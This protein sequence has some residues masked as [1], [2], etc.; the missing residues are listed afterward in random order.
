M[1]YSRL[2]VG[3][4]FLF[5]ERALKIDAPKIAQR[6]YYTY[7]STG[8]YPLQNGHN[9]KITAQQDLYYRFITPLLYSGLLQLTRLQGNR[10][11]NLGIK[12]HLR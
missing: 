8:T 4:L 6:G 3:L 11:I 9:R 5:K 1:L 7:K 10:A 2:T 12:I